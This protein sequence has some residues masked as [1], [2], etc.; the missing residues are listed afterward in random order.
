M[1]HRTHRDTPLDGY[2][3]G[4]A[5]DNRALWMGNDDLVQVTLR[6]QPYRGWFWA[7]AEHDLPADDLRE[8]STTVEM[9]MGG[10]LSTD[11]F[12]AAT[13]PLALLADHASNLRLFP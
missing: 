10:S 2:W 13:T 3:P 4:Q 7:R 12:L 5:W 6:F 1:E 8:L 9:T 11:L